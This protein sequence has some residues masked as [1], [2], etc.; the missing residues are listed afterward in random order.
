MGKMEIYH[1][2]ICN[3]CRFIANRVIKDLKELL[4]TNLNLE[5]LDAYL[6]PVFL[7]ELLEIFNLL[8]SSLS[9]L[10]QSLEFDESSQMLSHQLSQSIF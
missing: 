1:I 9:V 5:N 8:N 7:K 4:S 6:S 10:G 3:Q 2:T